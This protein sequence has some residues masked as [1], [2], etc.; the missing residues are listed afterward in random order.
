MSIWRRQ[1]NGPWKVEVD[2]G[3]THAG[4]ALWDQPLQAVVSARSR[5]TMQSVRTLRVAEEAFA[6]AS[7][8]AGARAAYEHHGAEDLRF[9]RPG[10][11]PALG[12]ASALQARDMT[13]GRLVWTADRVEAAH[14]G[15]FGYARGS[16]AGADEPSKVL[17]HYLRVWRLEANEWRVALDVTNAMPAP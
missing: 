7:A 11:A 6:R 16:Y 14:S 4:N 8:R 2:L 10:A 9:Y 15:D 3:I 17:G 12:K 13:A 5:G 1:G